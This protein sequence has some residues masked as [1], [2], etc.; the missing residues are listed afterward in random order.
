MLHA[1]TK[2][3][4]AGKARAL[5]LATGDRPLVE[6]SPFDAYWG[7]GRSGKGKNRLGQLLMQVRAKLWSEGE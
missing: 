3:F 5:L 6:T 1:L 7:C 2:K 4:A